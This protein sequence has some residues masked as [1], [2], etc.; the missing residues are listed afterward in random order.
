MN[1]DLDEQSQLLSLA[2]FIGRVLTTE[3]TLGDML[4]GC[5]QGLV[6]HLGAAF[7]RIWMFNPADDML[8]LHASAGMYTHLDGPHGRV[9]LGKFKIGM[10]ALDRVPHLTNSVVDDPR[11]SDQE[12]AR[13]EGIVSFAGYPLVMDDRLIGVVAMFSRR[14]L[15]PSTL[16]AIGS[17]ADEIAV[18]IER[19]RTEEALKASEELF[20]TAFAHAGVGLALT[21]LDGRFLLVN[22]AFCQIT[23]YSETEICSSG[24][25]LVTHPDDRR[26]DQELIA[27][28]M[29]GE[30][31]N[32]RIEKRYIREDG[33]VVW[34]HNSVSI[35]RDSLGNP[36]SI[37]SLS[38]DIS[39]Q[40]RTESALQGAV[41]ALQL[42]N[43]RNADILEAISDAFFALDQNWRYTYL[44]DQ[45]EQLIGKKR[46]HVIG[47]C[48]WDEQGHNPGSSYHR[49]YHRAVRDRAQVTFEEVHTSTGEWFEIRAFPSESGLAVNIHNITARKEL[50]AEK[51][52][53]RL[54]EHNIASQLQEALQPAIPPN[55]HGLALSK[56]YEPALAQTEGVGGDFYDVFAIRD[57]CTALIV[58]DLSGKGLAAA[59]QVATVR[60][61]LRACI[62]REETLKDAVNSLN[63]MLEENN[64]LTGF[65][66]LFVG[67]FD[68]ESKLL[69]YVNCGQE[70]AL[71][72]RYQTFSVES[73][74]PTGPIMGTIPNAEFSECTVQMQSGDAVVIFTDGIT[75]AGES[76]TNMLGIRGVSEVLGLPIAEDTEGSPVAVAEQLG[77]RL[78]NCVDSY[79]K[80]GIRDDICLL[81]AVVE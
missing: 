77:V 27:R 73:L 61:M 52:R 78:I 30:T 8:E 6:T 32:F 75:E 15:S 24:F 45:A 21:G 50:E 60:N 17:V 80:T 57:G 69:K 79:S 43:Q 47:K 48:I 42:A 40:R 29:S 49:E 19:L 12:W 67:A 64:L 5:A 51:E 16:Q 44:N 28:M 70:P 26:T 4:H 2:A 71:V 31:N 1:T 63:R 22:R 81:V 53:L 62:Y 20:R 58:G 54:R 76:R 9:P 13:R 34:V 23:G 37:V 65:T 18:G 68:I 33:N 55:V 38:E 7:A 25:V 14:T 56:Y 11:V 72:R 59:S 46:E 41:D 10:I 36:V 35:V 74:D 3:V 39:E 66:T